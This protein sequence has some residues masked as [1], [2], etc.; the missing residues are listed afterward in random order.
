MADKSPLREGRW[1]SCALWRPWGRRHTGDLCTDLV[2]GRACVSTDAGL[3]LNRRSLFLKQRMRLP[4]CSVLSLLGLPVLRRQR[5]VPER[6]RAR[7][8]TGSEA[9]AASAGGISRSAG[10]SRRLWEDEDFSVLS[11]GRSAWPL[12]HTPLREG[13]QALFDGGLYFLHRPHWP[14]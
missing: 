3:L 8:Q 7:R 2:S 13:A 4:S 5:P 10:C 1:Q 11:W 14:V 6:L 9:A 12:P